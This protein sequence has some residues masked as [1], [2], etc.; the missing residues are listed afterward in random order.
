MYM[1]Y[2]D[3]EK[4]KANAKKYYYA[5]KDKCLAYGKRRNELNKHKNCR[6]FKKYYQNNKESIKQ[7]V[8]EYKRNH[9]DLYNKLNSIYKKKYKLKVNAQTHAKR[10]Q[11]GTKCLI[12][13]LIESLQFHHT[14]YECRMGFT[15]CVGHHN[16]QHKLLKMYPDMLIN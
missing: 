9:R 12:C 15:A 11:R 16:E 14:D 7:R 2:K 13:G 10:Y 4:S 3:K 1:P 8:K 5:H 6:Y